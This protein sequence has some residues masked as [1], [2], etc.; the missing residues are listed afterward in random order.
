MKWLKEEITL[1]RWS[2]F[3]LIIYT[4]VMAALVFIR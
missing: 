1:P 2:F 3:A 4:F